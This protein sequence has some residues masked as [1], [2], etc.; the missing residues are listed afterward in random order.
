MNPYD[1]LD[2]YEAAREHT[3]RLYNENETLLREFI[4]DEQIPW[5]IR[6]TIRHHMDQLGIL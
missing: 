2:S 4:E 6:T 3:T 5:R 1:F